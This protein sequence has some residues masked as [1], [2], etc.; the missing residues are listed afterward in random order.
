M[1]PVNEITFEENV[2]A[3]LE[4]LSYFSQLVGKSMTLLAVALNLALLNISL[5]N[6]FILS[7]TKE[8]FTLKR[9]FS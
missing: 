4:D 9:L 8:N 2:S 1:K 7:K 3:S 5:M 6:F